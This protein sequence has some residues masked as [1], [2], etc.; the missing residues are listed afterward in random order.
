V[1]ISSFV[2]RIAELS[3]QLATF[4]GSS[5]DLP[6]LGYRAM[7]LYQSVVSKHLAPLTKILRS[8]FVK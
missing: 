4:N 6:I 1:L 5:F 8:F 3:P 7:S 2:A